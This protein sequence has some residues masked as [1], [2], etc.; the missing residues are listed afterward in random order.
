MPSSRTSSSFGPPSTSGVYSACS[1]FS[2]TPPASCSTQSV[3]PST[4]ARM[5][6]EE[7]L[8]LPAVS[9]R[10]TSWSLRLLELHVSHSPRRAEITDCANELCPDGLLALSAIALADKIPR[11]NNPRI[12]SMAVLAWGGFMLVGYSLLLSIFRIKNG[13]YPFS[14]PPFL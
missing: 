9:N 13:G 8:T 4:Q 12:Q 11:L 1:G 5:E 10:N 14:L 7:S 2:P 6:R 3:V